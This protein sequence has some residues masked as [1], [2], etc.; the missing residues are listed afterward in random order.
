MSIFSDFLSIFVEKNNFK[1]EEIKSFSLFEEY[2]KELWE[3]Y[4]DEI[5]VATSYNNIQDELEKYK[6]FS[7]R[8]YSEYF[9]EIFT[10][11]F[12]EQ[13]SNFDKNEL[14]VVEV[15]MHWTRYFVRGF[16]HMKLL[17][18]KFSNKN[19]IKHKSILKTYFTKRQVKLNKTQRLKNRENKYFIKKNIEVP[20]KIILIDDIV[21]TGSSVNFCAKILK[22]NWAKQI[23]V[24]AIATNKK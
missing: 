20:E 2:K 8:N 11:I 12:V 10:K 19:N 23:F 17:A 5:F 3:V 14:C 18:K 15:P 7:D 4:F 21:S 22:E 24:F 16:D 9:S 1:K 6:F 13:M